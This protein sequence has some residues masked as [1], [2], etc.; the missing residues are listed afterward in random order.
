MATLGTVSINEG[1]V[2]RL[3]FEVDQLRE[4]TQISPDT[5]A[6]YTEDD[7]EGERFTTSATGEQLTLVPVVTYALNEDPISFAYSSDNPTKIDV[8]PDGQVVFM[9]APEAT[10][11]AIITIVST[12]GTA[13]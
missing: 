11:S 6:P 3:W 13:A 1:K 10:A 5:S 8:A 7:K 4:P 12:S 9:V 2:L